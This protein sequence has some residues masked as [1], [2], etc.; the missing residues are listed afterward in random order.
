MVDLWLK[1]NKSISQTEIVLG[2]LNEVERDIK[3]LDS[4][5]SKFAFTVKED[6]IK[7]L[8]MYGRFISAPFDEAYSRMRYLLNSNL[9]TYVESKELP[10]LKAQWIKNHLLSETQLD[11][12]NTC[13]LWNYI[14]FVLHTGY[15]IHLSLKEQD[16][17]YVSL[18]S[19]IATR[20][21]L[22]PFYRQAIEL[23]LMN[24]QAA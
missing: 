8:R 24:F 9:S 18:L 20:A 2:L 11:A 5:Y 15:H 7:E 14:N 22:H 10:N 19:R 16:R 13:D 17:T 21:D 6:W 4:K 3:S 23:D 12:L 1:G